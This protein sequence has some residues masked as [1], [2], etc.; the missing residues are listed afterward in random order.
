MRGGVFLLHKR[1]LLNDILI[2]VIALERKA[3]A[4]IFLS[5]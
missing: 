2:L 3:L 4:I 5:Y 1:Y